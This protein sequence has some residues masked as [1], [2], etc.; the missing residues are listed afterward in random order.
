MPYGASHEPGFNLVGS[1]G[2]V[3]ALLEYEPSSCGV[4]AER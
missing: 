4:P 1:D 3:L 2:R